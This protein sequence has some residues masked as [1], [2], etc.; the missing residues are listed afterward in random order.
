MEED[1]EPVFAITDDM[2]NFKADTTTT[3]ATPAASTSAA[4]ASAPEPTPL[5]SVKPFLIQLL[6]LKA[7][8]NTTQ[9]TITEILQLLRQTPF[10][11][12]KVRDALPASFKSVLTQTKDVYAAPQEIDVCPLDCILF[13]SVLCCVKTERV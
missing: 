7:T 2:I 8:C 4:S 1:D 11:D 6:Q 10:V 3:T 12:E 13:R 9:T 5:E